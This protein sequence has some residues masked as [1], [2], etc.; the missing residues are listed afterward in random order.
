MLVTFVSALRA[1]RVAFALVV[2][3]WLVG[4]CASL[5][6]P[7][8]DG[9]VVALTGREPLEDFA[10]N[11]R[12]SLRYEDKNFSGRLSWQHRGRSDALLLASPFGQGMAEIAASDSEARLLTSDGRSYVAA[13]VETLTRDVLGYPLPLSQLTDWVRGKVIEGRLE[14]DSRGRPSRLR[15]EDWRIDYEYAGEDPQALPSLIIAERLGA[16]ELRLRIDEWTPF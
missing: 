11:G 4:G 12:F 16:F 5:S 7:A 1:G 15:H 6:E 3:G 10:L 8:V 14:R 9:P 13:D 2:A